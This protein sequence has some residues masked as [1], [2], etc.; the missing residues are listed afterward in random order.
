MRT[1][2]M[3]VLGAVFAAGQA[4][5]SGPAAPPPFTLVDLTGAYAAFYDR[6]Q[7]MAARARVEALKAEFA[8]LFPGFY[9]AE[10]VRAF[11]TPERYEVM[12]ARSFGEFADLRPRYERTAASFAT[13]LA[14]ARDDFARRFPDLAPLGEVHLVHSLG[15]MDGGLRTIGGRRYF[16]FGADV[17][18]RLYTPGDERPFFQ[19]ELF[20]VYHRQFFGECRAVW[21]A[22]W[23]EGL[24]VYVSEQLNPGATDAQLGLVVPR[25]IRPEVDADRARAVCA[26]H[27]RF[28]SE[29]PEDYAP[30]FYGQAHLA[31]LPPRF[32][33]YVGYLV[34]R[35][36]ARTRSLHQLAH[37]AVDD[38]RPLV[39][40]ALAALAGCAAPAAG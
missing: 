32:A 13:M 8:P 28:D 22:L 30:L 27:A 24:A 7:G 4:L 38:A 2:T 26:V 35:E 21:C 25:P 1:A 10:R 33:Y 11:A 19:H 20:H 39:A 3:A 29:R 15:E 18:A 16:V 5:A 6:T 14:P 17:M 40:A 34:A 37:L 9:D 12:I 31:G 36:A 23:S